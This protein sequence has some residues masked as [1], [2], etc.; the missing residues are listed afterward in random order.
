MVWTKPAASLAPTLTSPHL[1][2]FLLLPLPSPFFSYTSSSSFSPSSF[3]TISFSPP[4][5]PPPIPSFHFSFSSSSRQT[6]PP[7][8]QRFAFFLV[9]FLMKQHKCVKTFQTSRRR[10]VVRPQVFSQHSAA[11]SSSNYDSLSV[12]VRQNISDSNEPKWFSGCC[13]EQSLTHENLWTC[14]KQRSYCWRHPPTRQVKTITLWSFSL[15]ILVLF[16]RLLIELWQMRTQ[17]KKNQTRHLAADI[18][19]HKLPNCARRFWLCFLFIF[20]FFIFCLFPLCFL[21]WFSLPFPL[22]RTKIRFLRPW[23][24]SAYLPCPTSSTGIKT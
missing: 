7:Q 22:I 6:S 18:Q 16:C 4:S 11:T 15:S 19:R 9:L 1:P 12:A 13:S 14:E 8:P 21:Y 2:F 5:I 3:K 23:W 17:Q 10:R 20:G 24:F